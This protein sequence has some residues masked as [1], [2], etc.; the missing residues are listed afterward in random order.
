MLM[1][2]FDEHV[3]V[4]KNTSTHSLQATVTERP[5]G[6][7]CWQQKA[8]TDRKNIMERQ[9]IKRRRIASKDTTNIEE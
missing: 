2:N 6:L 8:S 7:F 5:R 1:L 9:N 4:A 3:F